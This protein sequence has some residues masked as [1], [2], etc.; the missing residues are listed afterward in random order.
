LSAR[1]ISRRRK[2]IA[3]VIAGA[4][5]LAQAVFFPAFI[6][7]AA[8]PFDDVLDVATAL[9]I[10]VTAGFEWRLAFALAVELVPAVDLFPTWTAVVLSIPSEPRMMAKGAAP[11]AGAVGR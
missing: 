8:S 4:S 11:P 1:T 3:L 5:D 7:G 10:L 9:A 2:L 6:E